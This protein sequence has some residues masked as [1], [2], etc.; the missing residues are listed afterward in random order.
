VSA[1]V[2]NPWSWQEQFGFVHGNLAPGDARTLYIAGQ[3]SVDGEGNPVHEGDMLGQVRQS[4]DN[5]E[6]VCREAGMTLANVVRINF[7]TTD[8]DAFFEAHD[9]LVERYAET[10]CKPVSTLLG[11]T[12]L[13]F[14]QMLVELEATA[15]G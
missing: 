1:E 2:I 14:P 3:A 12:R 4:L 7:Y 6:A 8:I 15:V 9:L 11:V 5:V 13:A 10:G